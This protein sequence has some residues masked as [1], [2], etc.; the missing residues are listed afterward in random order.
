MNAKPL[1]SLG[2]EA[3]LGLRL[4][5]D[6]VGKQVLQRRNKILNVKDNQNRWEL[7]FI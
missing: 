1:E 5:E 6:K 3:A 7:F 4:M 2:V